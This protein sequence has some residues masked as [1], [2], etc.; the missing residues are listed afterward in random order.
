MEFDGMNDIFAEYKNLNIQLKEKEELFDKLVIE[1]EELDSKY[2][3]YQSEFSSVEK[4]LIKKKEEIFLGKDNY[5]SKRDRI[6]S[7]NVFAFG[8]L[9]PFVSGIIF[10]GFNMS[11]PMWQLVT[12]SLVVSMIVGGIEGALFGKKNSKKYTKE[13]FDS[14]EYKDL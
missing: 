11:V 1:S 7:R 2:D 14:V 13:Y 5:V 10:S 8:F 4:D 3:Q 9:I 6:H 12:N